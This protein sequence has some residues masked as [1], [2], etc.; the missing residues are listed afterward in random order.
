MAERDK[1]PN[2][3]A[4]VSIKHCTKDSPMDIDGKDAVKLKQL[5]IHDDAEETEASIEMDGS[6]MEF[7]CPNC[8]FTYSAY[9]G[10]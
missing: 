9:V 8:K 10:D 2:L 4:D 1:Y 5:W 3:A 6:W 7:H